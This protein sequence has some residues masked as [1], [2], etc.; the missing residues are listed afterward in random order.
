MVEITVVG[1]LTIDEI[2]RRGESKSF[3]GGV[4]CYAALA[5]RRL[6]ARVKVVSKV[7]GDFPKSYLDILEKAGVDISGVIADPASKSTRFLLDY[8]AG[9]R[10]LKLA[11][12][13]GDISIKTLS[14]DAVYLGPVAWEIALD[15]V[16][17]AF[18]SW[19]LALLDPQG[20]MRFR[21][22]DGSIGLRKIDLNLKGLW[23]LRI[24]REEAEV[25]T[26]SRDPAEMI[27]ALAETGAENV[28]LTLGKEGAIAAYGFSKLMVPCFETVEVDSTGA[29]DVF[30]GA[31]L[32]EY[33][34]TGD[35]KWAVAMGSAMASI[36]VEDYGFYPLLREGVLEEARRRA[37]VIEES[38]RV[39]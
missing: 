32:A 20:L 5:A 26:S 37:E 38:I 30:G 39:L 13:A 31:F 10:A 35:F 19:K 4:A 6:G 16:V 33:L 17:D 29:G 7:G 18:K 14:G 8:S 24:S 25:L 3:M 12:R 23:T 21:K 1:H 27:R 2:T 15:E 28:V 22:R 9:R 36:L 34:S 11:S